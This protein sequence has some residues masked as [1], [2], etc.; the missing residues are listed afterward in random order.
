[1][2]TYTY[3][4]TVFDGFFD[5]PDAVREF[6]LLQN[7]KPEESGKWPGLRT[8]C[9]SVLHPTL[10]RQIFSRLFSVFF[11]TNKVY[12]SWKG[13]AAFQ[14]TPEIYGSGWVHQDTDTLMTGVIYLN[15]GK[16][17]ST[18]SICKPKHGLTFEPP[19]GDKKKE[20]YLNP[21]L[22]EEYAPYKNEANEL[23]DDSIVIS[24]EYNRLVLFEG[25]KHHKEGNFFG[26]SVEDS[27]L[28]LVVFISEAHTET[29]NN[30]RYRV[31]NAVIT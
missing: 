27:R 3:P 2:R 10:Y 18:I 11:E 7:Y 6:A 13:T 19:N 22:V 31:N 28:T 17:K 20:S 5:D 26:T 23:F 4:T 12:Y 1:M 25:Y 21:L 24:T 15:P 30:P 14:Y 8:E 16:A 9:L 29:T